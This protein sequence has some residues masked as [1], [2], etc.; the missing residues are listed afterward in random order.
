MVAA[1]RR[2]NTVSLKVTININANNKIYLYATFHEMFNLNSKIC[3]AFRS[4]TASAT[5]NK[6]NRINVDTAE[7]SI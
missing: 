2:K 6:I 1:C 3:S 4:V 7:Q 5:S